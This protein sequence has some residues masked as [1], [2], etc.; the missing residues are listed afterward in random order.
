MNGSGMIQQYRLSSLT[1]SGLFWVHKCFCV[2]DGE[3]PTSVLL[4]S[5]ELFPFYCSV[6]P[7][8]RDDAGVPGR[9]CWGPRQSA[10]LQRLPDRD[11]AVLSR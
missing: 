6:L 10:G 8:A 11:A 3:L 5:R 2:E 4:R 9:L 1:F 7:A